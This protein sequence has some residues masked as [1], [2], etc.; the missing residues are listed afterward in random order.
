MSWDVLGHEWAAQLLQSHIARDEVRHAYLFSGPPGVGR[1]TLAVRFAQALNCIQ[2]P[3]PGQP[4]GQ[5]RT[6]RQ[7][8]K[9]QHP[10]LSVIEA[11][12]EGAVIKIEQIR[13][14]QHS[15]SLAPYDAKYRVALMLR[16]QEAGIA[17]QNALLK[18]LEEA[19][20]RVVLL[21]VADTPE[22]LLPTIT[23]RCEILRL[24]PL[25]LDALAGALHTR[26]NLDD[27]EARLLAHLSSGRPG[28]A[29][30]LHAD[31][32]E[33]EKRRE[34]IED[35]RTLLESNRRERIAYAET[36]N[37]GK[38]RA[39]VRERLRRIFRVWSS[40][41][42]DLMLAAS[43]SSAPFI[44]LD[45]EEEIRSMAAQIDLT[46]AYARVTD[47]EQAVNRLESNVNTLLLTEVLLLDWPRIG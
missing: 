25:R 6:C 45:C 8:E 3:E 38:E 23:S 1:R 15:L 9:L 24:R 16:F 39:A 18:T 4:C 21:L 31:S 17:A 26:W 22:S 2:P 5:C 44:N 7:I 14:L 33:L 35:L 34:W 30:R 27:E 37:R 12:N 47:L 42:R 19:P 13:E 40:Y 41:W 20:A 10:D 32:D 43:G 46:T 29:L 11:E 28:Y 36:M